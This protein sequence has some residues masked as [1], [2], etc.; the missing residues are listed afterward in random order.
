MIRAQE[1]LEAAEL[2]VERGA[3]LSGPT[4]MDSPRRYLAERTWPAPSAYR[5]ATA[6][7]PGVEG[8]IRCGRGEWRGLAARELRGR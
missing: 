5:I 7:R 1:L 6:R 2:P 4:A 8:P 3:Q